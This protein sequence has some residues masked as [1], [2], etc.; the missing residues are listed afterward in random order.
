MSNRDII[1]IGASAG[2]VEALRQLVR[3]LPAD[4]PAAVLL[5]IH[6]PEHGTSVLPQILRRSSL[7]PVMHATDGEQILPGRVYVARP[8]YHML[9]RPEGICLVRGPKENGNRPAIDPLFRS[10]A[11]AFGRRVIG[12][13]LT[14]NLDDGTSG[15]ASIKRRGGLAVVQ[16]PSDALFPSMPRS[17][18]EN[19]EVDHVVAL[20]QLPQLLVRL[21]HED[22]DV[23]NR[24][25]SPDDIIEDELAAADLGAIEHPAQHPGHVSPYSCPDCGGV[26]WELKDGEFSRFRCRVGH[27]WT[28]EALLAEQSDGLD[29]ALWTALRTLEESAALARQIAARQRSKGVERLAA[30]FDEQAESIERRAASIRDVLME[31]RDTQTQ[32]DLDRA[33]P[34]RAS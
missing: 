27:A 4:L 10:A 24:P 29:V 15:L 30:R 13:V 6:F 9:V 2:G 33:E 12:V 7:L 5:T 32:P 25:T 31:Q 19:V 11:V 22:V 34:R 14:G 16:D 3:S 8:D 26:L 28:G 23:R 21:A 17:A 1:V 18:I 20:D